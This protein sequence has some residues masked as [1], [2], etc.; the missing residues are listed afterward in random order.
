MHQILILI[1]QMFIKHSINY[2]MCNE[3]T[4]NKPD[5]EKY[6]L[7]TFATIL[8]LIYNN[9]VFLFIINIT[10][11]DILVKLKA[12][13]CKKIKRD[14]N[15]RLITSWRK[16]F[17]KINIVITLVCNSQCHF[18]EDWRRDRQRVASLPMTPCSTI[19]LLL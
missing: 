3:V 18:V 1:N 6:L 15:C 4:N 8:K 5:D 19:F 11:R 9:S 2:L 12:A 16:A 17:S 13:H 10:A 7:L 14:E